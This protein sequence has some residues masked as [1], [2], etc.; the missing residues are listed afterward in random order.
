MTTTEIVSIV[1]AI[2][3]VAGLGLSIYNLYVNRRDK[4]PLLRSKISNG[5][6]TYGPELSDVMLILE[7]ANP[8]EKHVTVSAVEMLFGKEKAIFPNI[9]GTNRLPFELQSGQNASFWTPANEFASDLQRRG[10]KGKLKIRANFRDAV[11]NNY[12]SNKFTI[13]IDEWTKQQKQRTG[14]Q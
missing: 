9:Q 12:A 11:G 1:T 2:V 13:N 8:G 4:R 7:V 10:Y 3:A 14:Y 6:L 5:F